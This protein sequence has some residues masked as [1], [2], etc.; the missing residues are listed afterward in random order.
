MQMKVIILFCLPAPVAGPGINR[1]D[2]K[3]AKMKI[4]QHQ[5]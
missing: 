1:Q 2:A 3:S 4:N 5:E